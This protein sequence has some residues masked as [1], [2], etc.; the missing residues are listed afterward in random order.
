M[1]ATA[2]RVVFE[3]LNDRVQGFQGRAS[4]TRA[5]VADFML[6]EAEKASSDKK[7]PLLGISET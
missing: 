5:D 3:E 2:M 4:I 7:T 1:K 6:R